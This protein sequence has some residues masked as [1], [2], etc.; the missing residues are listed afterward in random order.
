[1]ESCFKMKDKD[2]KWIKAVLQ[3]DE[4]STD[5]ELKQYFKENGLTDLEII[6]ILNQRERALNNIEFELYL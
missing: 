6:K 5:D 4:N 2:I 1:M 3:N